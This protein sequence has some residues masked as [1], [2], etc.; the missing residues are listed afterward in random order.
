MH[1][2]VAG[3]VLQQCMDGLQ[4]WQQQCCAWHQQERD[5]AEV[6]CLGRASCMK[7]FEVSRAANDRRGYASAVELVNC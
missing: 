5:R 3:T 2:L 6:A 4:S 7:C 1:T